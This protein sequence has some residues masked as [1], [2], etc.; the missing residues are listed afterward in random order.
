MGGI[1]RGPVVALVVSYLALGWLTHLLYG[2]S[3]VT[4]TMGVAGA[5]VLLV[6]AVGSAWASAQRR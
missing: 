3:F 2:G 5:L 4:A 1:G 6:V